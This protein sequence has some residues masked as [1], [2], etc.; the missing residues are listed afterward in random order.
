MATYAYK[1]D[2]VAQLYKLKINL[3]QQSYSMHY[4][5]MRIS[6]RINPSWETKYIVKLFS[7]LHISNKN[8]IVIANQIPKHIL[9][10]FPY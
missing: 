8:C 7:A 6:I 10:N 2:I 3:K 9:P 5:A 4:L 1:F